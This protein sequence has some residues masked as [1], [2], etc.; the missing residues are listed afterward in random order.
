MSTSIPHNTLHLQ[1]LIGRKVVTVEGRHVGRVY[2][3]L[4]EPEGD[5][6]CLSALLVGPGTWLGRYGWA[7]RAGGTVVRWEDIEA[8]S[9]H[10][11]VRGLHR[12]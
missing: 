5:H 2:E 1:E 12:E 4:A 11:V 6:L 8:C 3:A 9:P 10:I 7:K